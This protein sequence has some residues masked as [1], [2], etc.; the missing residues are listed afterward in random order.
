MTELETFRHNPL[1]DPHLQIWGW[2]IPVYL[3]LGGLTAGVM[4][5]AA[6]AGMRVRDEQ[7]SRWMRWMPFAAPVLLSAGMLALFLD[8]SNK[9]HVFRFYTA[10][11]ITSPMSWGSW[12]LLLI[13]PAALLLG[14]AQLTDEEVARLASSRLVAAAGLQRV[15]LRVA[16]FARGC[17]RRLERANIILGIALGGYT[18]ILLGTL[19]ARAAW[20]SVMLG[21]LFLVSGISTGV[22]LVMLF[23]ITHDERL[24]LRG[25]D[26]AAI[27]TEG[28]L[29]ALFFIGLVTGGERGR[30][31]AALFFGGS[32]TAT[33]WSIVV[34]GGLALP[35]LLEILESRRRVAV[36]I[37]APTLLLIGGF[38][39]R[40]IVV[41]AGQAAI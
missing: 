40:W 23:P 13:Y 39:L 16:A 22:A 21:P 25:W 38:A 14:M 5:V 1:I 18:G 26:M 32:Y 9:I 30:A 3:F 27:A 37:I 20:S 34:I 35:L 15:L 11:R 4:I 7:Q 33:F 41:A 12:I 2:E 36:T 8:L 10:F 29:L 31:A 17:V 19:G 28:V 6:L 24:M